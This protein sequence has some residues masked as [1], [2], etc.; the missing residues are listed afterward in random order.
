MKRTAELEQERAEK[1]ARMQALNALDRDLTDEEDKEFDA[2]TAR[3]AVIDKEIKRHNVQAEA[4]RNAPAAAVVR[5]AEPRFERSSTWGFEQPRDF[6]MAVMNNE[7]LRERDDVDDERLKALAVIG[8][9]DGSKR[10]SQDL[11]YLMPRGFAALKP[12]GPTAANMGYTIRAAAGSDEHS[13]ADDRYG[14]ALIQPTYLN[15]LLQLSPEG[16]PTAGRTQSIPMTSLT[17][18][19]P[20]R[21]DK[22]HTTSVSGGLT[23]GR[24]SEIEAVSATRGQMERVNLTAHALMGLSYCTEELLSFSPISFAAMLEADYRQE[25]AA[26]HLKEVLFGGGADDFQGVVGAACSVAYSRQTASQIAG[27][28]V[29]GMRARMWGYGNAIWLANHDTYTQLAKLNIGIPSD[30]TPTNIISVYQPSLVPDRPD[31]LLGKP[32]YYTEFCETLG[33]KGDLVCINLTQFL[34]G[35]LTPI[36]SAESMHVRFTNHER[37]FKF[38]MMNCGAPWWRSALTPNQSSTTLSPFVILSDAS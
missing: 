2:A 17:V 3:I 10:R 11:A 15:Q 34:E 27:R 24:R 14:G 13:V 7:G 28:D 22:N 5:A 21:T 36:Q 1:L 20:A 38:W 4:E 35:T 37:A 19:I 31:M 8:A 6:F 33:T 29:M 12:A 18:S 25:F 23:V 30:T 32:I 16:D 26:N 9:D